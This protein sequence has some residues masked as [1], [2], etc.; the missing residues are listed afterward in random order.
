MET[1]GA[2][3]LAKINAL[4]G[5]QEICKKLYT[6]PTDAVPEFSKSPLCGHIPHVAAVFVSHLSLLIQCHKLSQCEMSLYF[7]K[8]ANFSSRYRLNS[9]MKSD[10]GYKMH[11]SI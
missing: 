5:P 7:E 11:S 1:R 2:E 6:S 10:T 9:L 4:G 3:G 8:Y